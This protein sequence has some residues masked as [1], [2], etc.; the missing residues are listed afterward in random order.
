MPFT[1][2]ERAVSA[3]M[4]DVGAVDAVGASRSVPCAPCS[5]A[6]VGGASVQMLVE[7]DVCLSRSTQCTDRVRVL[8]IFPFHEYKGIP[9]S[10][11]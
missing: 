11:T 8:S 4:R 7:R 1:S 3:A 5:G 9:R 10:K 2:A 6:D